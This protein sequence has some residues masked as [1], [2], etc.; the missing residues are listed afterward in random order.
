MWCCTVS[1]QKVAVIWTALA[2]ALGAL[3]PVPPVPSRKAM[4]AVPPPSSG[5]AGVVETLK[6]M[7]LVMCLSTLA[8]RSTVFGSSSMAW[9]M[10]PAATNLVRSCGIRGVSLL[11]ASCA[12]NLI[13]FPPPMGNGVMS[14]A[15][16]VGGPATVMVGIPP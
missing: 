13:L 16:M 5:L 12:M 2:L 4:L 14:T 7:V 15:G 1:I 6:T 3:V 9:V 11:A 10:V 8:L